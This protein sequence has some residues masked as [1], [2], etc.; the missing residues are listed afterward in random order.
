MPESS[1]TIHLQTR[2]ESSGAPSR[3]SCCVFVGVFVGVHLPLPWL[4]AT[5]RE[6][7]T[8]TALFF[9]CVGSEA[10]RDAILFSFC[11][12][13]IFRL[14][15]RRR[16]GPARSQKI[17]YLD[18][19]RYEDKYK[20]KASHSALGLWGGTSSRAPIAINRAIIISSQ[21]TLMM[22]TLLLQLE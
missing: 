19:Y 14:K 2:T 8:V 10:A 16:Q 1:R 18:M 12:A 4:G 3:A 13:K 22:S 17:F 21:F 11:R 15:K 9:L 6:E 7:I 5:S 20:R